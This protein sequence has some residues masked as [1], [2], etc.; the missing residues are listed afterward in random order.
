[1]PNSKP[2]STAAEPDVT[3][4]SGAYDFG[5]YVTKQ[6]ILTFWYQLSEI[7]RLDAQSVLEVGIGPKVV[8]GTLRELGKKLKTADINPALKPDYLAPVQQLSSVVPTDAFDVVLCARVL[9]H[10]PFDEIDQ[11]L[12][13]LSKVTRRY[14]VLTLPVDELRVYLGAGVTSRSPRWATLRVPLAIKR[15]VFQAIPRWRDS[16]YASRWKL[17]R[18]RECSLDAF[19][20]KLRKHFE[21]EKSYAMPECREHRMFVLR[22][23]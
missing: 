1:M 12:A 18:S 2:D 9:H 21:I 6:R 22:K 23:L 11:A 14:V 17:G 13:E 19:E 20:A 10:V 7:L 5:R 3:P 4:S 8:A 16:Y 15:L